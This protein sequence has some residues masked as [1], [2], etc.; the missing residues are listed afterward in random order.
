MK[1]IK[2]ITYIVVLTCLLSACAESDIEPNNVV[3]T[4]TP[5]EDVENNAK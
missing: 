1:L 4:P 5:T 2:K 3:I